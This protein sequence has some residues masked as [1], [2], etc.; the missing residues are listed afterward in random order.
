MKLVYFPYID[1]QPV[2][3]RV[4]GD[5]Y[6]P[7]TLLRPSAE[8]PP[9]HLQALCDAGLIEFQ[10]SE[11]RTAEINRSVQAWREWLTAHARS[12]L[13]FMQALGEDTPVLAEPQIGRLKSEIERYDDP[14]SPV[15]PSDDTRLRA[16]AFLQL[17]ADFD[18]RQIELEEELARLA[19]REQ[20]MFRNL[21][22][23]AAD[24]PALNEESTSSLSYSRIMHLDSGSR[25]TRLRLQSW[26]VLLQH[27]A[28][29][30]TIEATPLFIT[31]SAAVFQM[32]LDGPDALQL[33]HE[34]Y[35]FSIDGS[36]PAN[37]QARFAAWLK[38]TLTQP[39]IQSHADTQALHAPQ[40]DH[41]ARLTLAILPGRHPKDYFAHFSGNGQA[42]SPRPT[43]AAT[44]IGLLG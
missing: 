34:P 22:G 43:D 33:L 10:S 19:G 41:F 3:A 20:E 38:Q 24:T 21:S 23:E 42:S 35:I 12:D 15:M 18:H 27:S 14:K 7:I 5:A 4:L 29:V 28:E 40:D 9:P 26:N 32:L 1:I 25:L 37:Q 11:L 13:A 44:V 30:E 39:A 2:I 8:M 17:T 31:S 16:G 36:S 6:A